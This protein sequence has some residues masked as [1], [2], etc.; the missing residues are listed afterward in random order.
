MSVEGGFQHHAIATH[1]EQQLAGP[2]RA[3]AGIQE[4]LVEQIEELG[5]ASLSA[6]IARVG[7]AAR[8]LTDHID[9]L[10]QG[11]A[12]NP[13]T[14]VEFEAQLRHDLRTPLNAIIGYSELL[15]EEA[16]ELGAP[17]LKDDIRAILSAAADLM[18]LVDDI[19]RFSRA[20][21]ADSLPGAGKSSGI[22]AAG[23]ERALI[24]RAAAGPPGRILVVDDIRGN[25]DLLVRRLRRD[26]HHA[27]AV[28]TGRA[29]LDLLARQEFDLVLLDI[30]MP[31]MNGIEVLARLKA[32]VG[33][34][35]IP[36]IMISGLSEVDAVARCLEAGAD[37]YLAK[38]FN[39]VLLRARITSALEKKRWIDRERD[40]LEQIESEKRRADALLVAILPGQIVARLQR[41]EQV[42]A[43][44]FEAATI[45]F[46]DIVGFSSVA[47]RLPPTELIRRL[48]AMFGM[49]DSLAEMHGV[50]KI[51]TIGDAYMA[52][53]GIPEPVPDHARRVVALGMSMLESLQR[54]AE[55]EDRFHIRIGVHTGP[56]IAGLIGKRRFVYDVWGETVNIASRLESQGLAGKVQISEATRLA[57]GAA[58]P[59]DPQLSTELKGIGSI[60][61]YFVRGQDGSS[62]A[63]GP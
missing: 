29:A 22:D 4:L 58:W 56:V 41:G 61:T 23:L 43:D 11:K 44:R 52:A 62:R 54:S 47:G 17:A 16:H 12:D 18:G 40:Y 63:Y 25:R 48:D 57:L 1:A 46:A 3:I 37:D 34:R 26:G 24:P 31:D 2:A 50:E 51:K 8:Q 39:P 15:L 42:I 36:V 55:A 33:W 6:D 14:G 38:P 13:V 59:L 19:A 60:G 45:L 7:A 53:C 9:R 21:P 20:G 30:L 49:F 5:L 10:I 28:D 32:E 35:H 27:V